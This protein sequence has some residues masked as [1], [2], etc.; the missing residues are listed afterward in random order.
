[1]KGYLA[2][3]GNRWYAVIYEG[4]DPVTGRER[5]SWH[6]AGG[7][8]RTSVSSTG[9]PP[10]VRRPAHHP[11]QGIRDATTTPNAASSAPPRASTDPSTGFP[12]VGNPERRPHERLRSPQG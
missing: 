8:R 1:M 3:K 5:R 9:F 4:L 11:D 12:K 6:P 7:I 2:H 10:C